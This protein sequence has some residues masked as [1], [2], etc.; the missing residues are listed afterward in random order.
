MPIRAPPRTSVGQ[1]LLSW[2]RVK[3]TQPASAKGTARNISK[4]ILSFQFKLPF[5]KAPS[6]APNS[7]AKLNAPQNPFEVCPEGKDFLPSF[8]LSSKNKGELFGDM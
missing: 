8:A 4:G 2:M 3:P 7:K 6:E 1:C 5:P